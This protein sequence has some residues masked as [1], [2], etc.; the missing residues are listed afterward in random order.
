MIK[1]FTT[2][3][4]ATAL[5]LQCL[6][7][8]AQ[9]QPARIEFSKSSAVWVDQ[10][11]N[12]L[13]VFAQSERDDRQDMR[14]RQDRTELNRDRRRWRDDRR[15]AAWD[16]SMHN[17]YYTR[18]NKWRYGQPSQWQTRQPGFAMGYRP[19]TR[20]Q[21]LGA[22]NRRFSELDYRDHNLRA[23]PRGYRWVED[24]RGDYLLAA[25]VGGLIA[26]VIINSPR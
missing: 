8:S 13:I 15:D 9:A 26:Q 17:G 11:G 5:S 12:P 2:L 23:P 4:F 18:N 7:A 16:R 14:S 22:Y 20:G 24:D 6:G 10:N 25:I 21:S 3:A 1:H 19:W